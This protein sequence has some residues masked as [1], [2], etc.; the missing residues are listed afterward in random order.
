MN[1][2]QN[3]N[4]SKDLTEKEKKLKALKQQNNRLNKRM[5]KKYGKKWTDLNK[6]Q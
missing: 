1:Y 4:T 3:L 2:L 5:K 6:K